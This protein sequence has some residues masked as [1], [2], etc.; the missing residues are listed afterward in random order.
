MTAT[1]L[2]V[3][4]ARIQANPKLKREIAAKWA[5]HKWGSEELAKWARWAWTQGL[6][7]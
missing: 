3:D 5:G 1:E 6:R 2:M 4:L 7:Q